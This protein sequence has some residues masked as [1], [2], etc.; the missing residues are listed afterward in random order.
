MTTITEGA[1]PPPL[2][3]RDQNVRTA[4]SIYVLRLSTSSTCLPDG[5]C[6]GRRSSHLARTS[7]LRVAATRDPY[8][9]AT[10]RADQSKQSLIAFGSGARVRCTGKGRKRPLYT[11][12]KSNS[13]R[14]TDVAR[15]TKAVLM[16][17]FRTSTAATSAPTPRTTCSPN[18]LPLPVNAVRR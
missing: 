16:R 11:A 13:R 1:N 14:A 9:L 17:Y 10:I 5:H 6:L 4:P 3:D 7:R 8:W 15:R 18:T 2:I 12:I